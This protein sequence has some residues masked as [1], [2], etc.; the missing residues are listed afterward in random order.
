MDNYVYFLREIIDKNI[1]YQFDSQRDNRSDIE[2]FLENFSKEAENKYSRKIYKTLRYLIVDQ[3]YFILRKEEVPENLIQSIF[4]VA[5]HENTYY[6]M[7]EKVMPTEQAEIIK[8][9]IHLLN[10]KDPESVK[11]LYIDALS[12]LDTEL[13][14]T[15][16]DIKKR[17]E[18]DIYFKYEPLDNKY[19]KMWGISFY[20]IVSK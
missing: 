1:I 12:D 7:M 3:M 14:F 4:T 18:N 19:C 15:F 20:K 8:S 10:S 17:V 2:F 9:N 6:F 16:I 13:D 5:F 11:E